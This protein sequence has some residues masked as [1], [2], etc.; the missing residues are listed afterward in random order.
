[1][2]SLLINSLKDVRYIS[3]YLKPAEASI[4][5]QKPKKK[6]PNSSLCKRIYKSGHLLKSTHLVILKSL[7]QKNT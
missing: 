4:P 3:G 6:K 5:F 2:M 7:E 1:M